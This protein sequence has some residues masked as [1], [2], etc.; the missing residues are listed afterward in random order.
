MGELI[1]KQ[2]VCKSARSDAYP[3]GYFKGQ[4]SSAAI[5]EEGDIVDQDFDLSRFKVNPTIYFNHNIDKVIGHSVR[6]GKRSGN[7]HFEG[8]YASTELAQEVRTLAEEGHF[9]GS[10]GDLYASIRFRPGEIVLIDADG[11]DVEDNCDSPPG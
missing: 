9:T 8:P 4:A 2:F 5:D 11:K 3:Y 10:E 6:V 1:T 7:L